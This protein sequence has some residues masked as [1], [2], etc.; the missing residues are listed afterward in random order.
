VAEV[1]R[2]RVFARI[3]TVRRVGKMKV[4][5]Y[6]PISDPSGYSYVARW[7]LRELLKANVEIAFKEMYQWNPGLSSEKYGT[8]DI[9][10]KLKRK[11]FESAPKI[12][13]VLPDQFSRE[14]GMYNI[15]YS[16][17]ETDRISD[18]WAFM[19]NR[20]DECWV[21]TVFNY[22]TFRKSGVEKSKLR[23]MPFGVDVDLFS[24]KVEPLKLLETED[25]FVFFS[26][27][28]WSI[29]KGWDVLLK[30][31]YEEFSRDEDVCL[32]LK[33]YEAIPGDP[34][35]EAVILRDVKSI[36]R[37][38]NKALPKVLWFRHMLSD[39]MM[40][41]LYKA[42]DCFVSTTRGEG[43][44]LGLIQA[45]SMELPSIVT[46]WSAHTDYA[47]ESNAYMI[48][49]EMIE[50]HASMLWHPSYKNAFYA[51]PSIEHTRS[52]MRQVYENYEEA[53]A[54]GIQARKDIKKNY[55]WEIAAGRIIKRLQEIEGEAE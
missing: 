33:V 21:P 10:R 52:L 2:R 4:N 30:A 32:V 12:S 20:M 55:T 43:W 40:P 36:K 51:D 50:T 9:I 27:F 49:Y 46:G 44:G 16:M 22:N 45:M 13:L 29:R 11:A 7:L 37:R 24:P 6:S 3:M 31:Y 38:F 54:K 47:N 1:V 26:D 39:A 53:K 17:F 14:E 41:S 48:D 25:R 15:G 28:Q 35:S 23:V 5:W 18:V 19:C 34:R 8:N 42:A